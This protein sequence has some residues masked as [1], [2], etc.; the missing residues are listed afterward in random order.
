MDL[1][2]TPEPPAGPPP[3]LD[4]IADAL[5][6]SVH[7]FA[8]DHIRAATIDA[9]KRIPS[10]VLR[11]LAE[12][13]MFGV[14]L[15]ESH[16]GAGLPATTACR[17]VT[18]LAEHDRSVATTVGLHLGLGTRGLVAFGRPE[19]KDRFLP[20]LA[21]GEHVAAFATT[22]S[23]AGSD[24]TA[25]ATRGVLEGNRLR[26]NGQKIYVTNGG[27][28]SVLTATIATPGLNGAG[29]GTSV[30][31]LDIKT[32]GVTVLGEEHKLGLRG[33]STTTVMLEDALIPE[34]QLLGTPGNGAEHLSHILSWGRLL[35]SAG[36]VGTARTALRLTARHVHE[37]RQFGRTLAAQEVVQRQLTSMATRLFAMRA[38]VEAAAE[39]EHDREALLRLT[40]SS[41][42]LCS[43][44][45]GAVCDLAIQLHGGS[46]YIEDTGVA[47]LARDARVTRI[48][49]GANDVLLTHLGLMELAKPVTQP[50]A[51]LVPPL[52]SDFRASLLA[53]HGGLRVMGKKA[54]HHR[55]GVACA[56]RDAAVAAQH[57]AARTD[58]P[59]DR[60][61]ARL[62]ERL[63]VSQ[64][65][66]AIDDSTTTSPSVLASLADGALP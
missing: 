25:I 62:V 8:S 53:T 61:L 9:E 51:S 26:L 15:P 58:R 54:E 18:A 12:L 36:C 22:E 40:T 56:W 28:A 64:V 3:V 37:R 5:V 21:S 42:V 48:F 11:G 63:A 13:G 10:G 45:A 23:G 46:G 47:M 19:T 17:A 59:L 6:D 39:V 38:L 29:R 50:N 20:G 44:G 49:E 14:T 1:H 52:V 7:A 41:K 27:L 66:A 16:G 57:L 43:E 32:P 34:V 55:L 2:V 33:S 4:P 31:V 30:V 35:L 65:R 60:E 24:L